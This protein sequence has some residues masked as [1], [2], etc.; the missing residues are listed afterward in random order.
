MH[1]EGIR[2]LP[3]AWTARAAIGIV[4]SNMNR[5]WTEEVGMFFREGIMLNVIP[6]PVQKLY[7]NNRKSAVGDG[8]I[9]YADISGFTSITESLLEYGKR[10]DEV[11]S[12]ILSRVFSRA[13]DEIYS[14]G[15]IIAEF[16]G[17]AIISVFPADR[18]EAAYHAATGLGRYF[19]KEPLWETDIGR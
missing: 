16:E 18:P 1:E 9:L 5:C 19:E 13:I 6:R 15:G 8:I 4:T 7:L 2:R 11:L 17:D 3:G 14:N 12:G 10:G